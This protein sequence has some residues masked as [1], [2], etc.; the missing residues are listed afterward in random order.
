M[1]TMSGLWIPLVTPFYHGEVDYPALQ[2]LVHYYIDRDV[3]GL[4]VC[5]TTGE[6]LSLDLTEKEMVLRA[7]LETVAG[8]RPVL[9]GLSGSSTRAIAAEA[10][11]YRTSGVAGFLLSAPSY[12]K[13]SQAG[14]VA[15]FGQV[16]HAADL[17]I[18]IYNIPARTGVNMEPET[19][20]A[21]CT[22]D[23]FV[24]LKECGGLPQLLT[25]LANPPCPVLC[26]DDPLLL[27]ALVHGAKGA[28]SASAH[29]YPEAFLSMIDFIRDGE[30]EPARGIFNMLRPLI[31]LC[32]SEPNPGPVKAA[33]AIQGMMH[34]ELRLP[35]TQVS[36][37]CHAKIQQ[38]L[39]MLETL[40]Q[41]GDWNCHLCGTTHDETSLCLPEPL[42]TSPSFLP[43]V[44]RH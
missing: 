24:G 10:T 32:F 13:P 17:P 6:A 40:K 26:G 15:H 18:V 27:T 34:N 11:Q 25:L 31:Q 23:Q 20:A 30:L 38:A 22:S 12:V 7:V 28:I 42:V 2:R 36:G 1:L 14:I 33:L 35:M 16:A 9:M 5:G 44:Q 29:L 19:I 37:Q 43:A 4:V 39:S 41:R 3:D 8:R 21:I